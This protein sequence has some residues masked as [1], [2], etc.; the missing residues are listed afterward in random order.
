M[1]QAGKVRAIATTGPSR[2]PSLSEIPTFPESGFNLTTDNFNGVYLPARTPPDIVE[3]VHS[4]VLGVLQ[5][6]EVRQ[7]LSA[8]GLE[9][10]GNSQAEFTKTVIGEIAQ[11]RKVV[12]E[13]V[14][15]F[16]KL[17]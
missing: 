15:N 4:D 12:K 1:I 14:S 5:G 17:S 6:G 16:N 13:A 3:R 8:M 2:S 7:R 9:T 10:V 11:W